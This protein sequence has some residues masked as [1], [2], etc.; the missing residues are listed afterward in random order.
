MIRVTA[1]L[2]PPFPRN[3]R[4]LVLGCINTDFCN[5]ILILQH[6]S[7]STRFDKIALFRTALN[8]CKSCKISICLQKL[9]LIE[10]RTSLPKFLRKRL[11]HSASFRGNEVKL[12]DLWKPEYTIAMLKGMKTLSFETPSGG[13]FYSVVGVSIAFESLGGVVEVGRK[14]SN[15]KIL[16]V[17]SRLDG[18]CMSEVHLKALTEIHKMNPVLQVASLNI[19]VR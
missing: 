9:V 8:S 11:V 19:L 16:H 15:P 3:F 18:H 6:F 10:P 7:R 4:R 13:H 14:A 12:K 5:Q 1:I 2:D 17:R